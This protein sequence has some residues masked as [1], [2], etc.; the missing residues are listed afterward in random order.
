MSKKNFGLPGKDIFT[1]FK[2]TIIGYVQ[3]ITGCN[4]Y[5]LTPKTSKDNIKGNAHWIDEDRISI[6]YKAKRVT[7]LT[8]ENLGC[9]ISPS[10]DG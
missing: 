9:D 7:L 6:S 1:G 8:Q 4:Q 10:S 5:L 2:G 3:H